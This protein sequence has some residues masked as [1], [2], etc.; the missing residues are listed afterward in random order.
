MNQHG[1]SL[2]IQE[3]PFDNPNLSEGIV[4]LILVFIG[5]GLTANLL[6]IDISLLSYLGIWLLRLISAYQPLP[7]HLTQARG[8]R[9]Q[10]LIVCVVT[11]SVLALIWHNKQHRLTDAVARNY[12][13]VVT[14]WL[15]LGADVNGTDQSGNRPLANAVYTGNL[16]MVQ[17]LV[18]HGATVHIQNEYGTPLLHTAISQFDES[19]TPRHPNLSVV[20][21]LIASGADVNLK[22]TNGITP[23]MEATSSSNVVVTRELIALGAD[24]NARDHKGFTPLH[25]TT[26]SNSG[27]IVQLLLA[28]KADKDAQSDQGETALMRAARLNSSEMVKALLEQSCNRELKNKDGQT[29]LDLATEARHIAIQSLLTSKL[30]FLSQNPKYP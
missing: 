19:I 22:D 16:P 25:H 11:V 3:L 23:L 4:G 20:K 12:P 8:I 5:V 17:L 21:T 1:K 2:E 26:G 28:H 10:L 6:L 30:Y 24:V 7:P 15:W 9:R 29:A 27:K 18:R 14:T 13:Q